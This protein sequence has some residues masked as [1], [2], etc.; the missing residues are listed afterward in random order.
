[1]M[2]PCMRS[3]CGL[4]AARPTAGFNSSRPTRPRT[5]HGGSAANRCVSSVPMMIRHRGSTTST[6]APPTSMASPSTATTYRGLRHRPDSPAGDQQ[7]TYARGRRRR[8]GPQRPAASLPLCAAR[9][10]RST[11]EAPGYTPAASPR[12]RRRPF[13]VAPLTRT[14]Q[15]RARS[16]PPVMRSGCAPRTSPYLLGWSWRTIKRRNNT[17]FSRIPSRLAHRARSIR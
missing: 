5:Q 3:R 15:T 6:G 8:G 1:M 10:L 2:T 16:S 14:L 17:G 11:S 12:L 9:G 13:T 7:R 4:R